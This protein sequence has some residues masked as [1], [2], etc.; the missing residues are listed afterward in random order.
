ML[1]EWPVMFHEAKR[2]GTLP[3]TRT[4]FLMSN[5]RHGVKQIICR[6]RK[7]NAWDITINC[8]VTVGHYKNVTSPWNINNVPRPSTNQIAAFCLRGRQSSFQRCNL[9]LS[10][11]GVLTNENTSKTSD[12][13]HITSTRLVKFPLEG[14]HS[15][16]FIRN[17]KQ[18]SCSSPFAYFAVFRENNYFCF[19]KLI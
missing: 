8:D 19:F 12:L 15:L 7:Q 10:L 3:A 11:N 17:S 9:W 6:P 2:S 1:S 16:Y 4:T 18:G 14:I 5:D 13:L